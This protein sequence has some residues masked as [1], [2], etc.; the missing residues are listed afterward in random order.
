MVTDQYAEFD[1]CVWH[2][3]YCESAKAR[4]EIKRLAA[5]RAW[6]RLRLR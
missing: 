2:G 1:D 5:E 6:L 3:A 4:A